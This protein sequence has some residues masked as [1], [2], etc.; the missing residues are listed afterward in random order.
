VAELIVNGVHNVYINQPSAPCADNRALSEACAEVLILAHQDVYLPASFI[1]RLRSAV[2]D[3]SARD[4]PP[5]AVLGVFGATSDGRRLG[6]VWSSGLNR[7][8]G[9]SFAEPIPLSA[10]TNF[11]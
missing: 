11:F 5:W 10:W 2:C 7:E 3:L 9:K 8:L 1:G 4:N 6:R